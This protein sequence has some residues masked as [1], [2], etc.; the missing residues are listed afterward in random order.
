MKCFLLDPRFQRAVV[1][2]CAAN[3][4]VAQALEFPDSCR[5]SNEP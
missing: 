3:D 5:Y 4:F 2:C 1:D